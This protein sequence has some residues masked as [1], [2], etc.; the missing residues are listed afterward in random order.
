[1]DRRIPDLGDVGV[2][3]EPQSSKYCGVMGRNR[4]VQLIANSSSSVDLCQKEGISF[5][6][7]PFPVHFQAES[8]IRYGY[9]AYPPTTADGLE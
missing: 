1:M 2:S 7:L 9:F 5:L 6:F 4:T 3:E 8:Q